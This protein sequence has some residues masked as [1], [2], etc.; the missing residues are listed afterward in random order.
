M[1]CYYDSVK[2]YYHVSPS[3]DYNRY[4][5]YSISTDTWLSVV[6]LDV[7]YIPDNIKIYDISEDVLNETVIGLCDTELLKCICDNI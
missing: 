5:T 2:R 4:F 6:T 7:P 1:R 3:I